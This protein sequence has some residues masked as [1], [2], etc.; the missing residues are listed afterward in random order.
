M[1]K[2]V[3]VVAW[4]LVL[5]LLIGT[6]AFATVGSRTAELFYNNIKVMLN[7]KEITPTDANGN[8]IEPF[9]IDGTTY[10][11]VRG[12]ASALGLDVGWD[13]ATNTV[14]LN[15]PGV[16]S[17][18][19]Q[20]YADKN[21]IISFAGC[22]APEEDSWYDYYYADFYVTN[23]T[24]VTLTFQ[25]ES[26]SFNGVSYKVDGS[27]EVAPQSTGKI[28]FYTDDDVL[29]TSGIYKTSGEVSVIDMEKLFTSD[30]SS[31]NAKWVNVTQ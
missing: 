25:P 18:V 14:T 27:E 12:V 8:A 1:K 21:V 13:S 15:N 30:E 28:S 31:Y 7:G 3:K 4:T 16:F 22:R 9:I 29:P 19:V 10:L 20:V 5:T 17:N 6:T 2:K 24:D 23:K 11:P 26:I